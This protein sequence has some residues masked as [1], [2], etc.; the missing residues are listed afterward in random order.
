MLDFLKTPFADGPRVD[1]GEVAVRLLLALLFGVVVAW[2]Y[3]ATRRTADE[4]SSF[5][6]TIVLLTVLIAAVTQVIGDNVARAFSLVGTLSIVRFR[7]VVRDTHD[8]AYVILA[9]ITGMAVGAK[10]L[11]VAAIGIAVVFLAEVLL[12]IRTGKTRAAGPEYLLKVR[13]GVDGDLHGMIREAVDPFVVAR[14]LVSMGTGKQ[15]SYMEATY[16]LRLRPGV[17]E[18]DLV[19]A[20]NISPGVQSVQLQRRDIQAD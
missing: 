12:K 16:K 4:E 2:V 9:V 1:P 14:E 5:P 8:S 20:V 17:P 13:T 11:W 15:G 6:A 3:G 7:T 10:N 18:P 19:K